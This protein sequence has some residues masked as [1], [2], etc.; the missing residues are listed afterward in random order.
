MDGKGILMVIAGYIVVLRTD[1][2]RAITRPNGSFKIC[3]Y[4]LKLAHIDAGAVD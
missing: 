2:S 4:G 3:K 1:W